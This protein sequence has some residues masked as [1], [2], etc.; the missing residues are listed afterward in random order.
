MSLAECSVSDNS[1]KSTGLH[2]DH[3]LHHVDANGKQLGSW[4]STNG[5]YGNRVDC[6]F[7]H[8]LFGYLPNEV[9]R[10]DKQLYEAYLEQLSQ[11]SF[12]A[13]EK[14]RR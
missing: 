6:R 5:P 4:V 2:C 11:R 3:A 8:K 13:L 7:C 1:S 9:G 14:S 12:P 10:T